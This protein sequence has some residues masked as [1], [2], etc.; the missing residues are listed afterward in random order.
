MIGDINY[1]LDKKKYNKKIYFANGEFVKS[2]YIGTYHGYIND[3]KISLKK[4][5]YIFLNLKRTLFQLLA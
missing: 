2:K 1:I 4:C 3:N 5:F